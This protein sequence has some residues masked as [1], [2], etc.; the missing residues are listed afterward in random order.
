MGWSLNVLESVAVTTA[1]GLAVDFS[2]HYGIIY[3]LSAENCRESAVGLTLTRMGGPTLMA[4]LTTGAA[5]F[6][7]LPSS[8]LAYIQ[9]VLHYLNS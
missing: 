9:V 4:A 8:V 3:G 6:F 1:I 5:G 2:L 7:M